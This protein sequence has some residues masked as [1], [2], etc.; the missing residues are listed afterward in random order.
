[1][2]AHTDAS[3]QEEANW[4]LSGLRAITVVRSL[5]QSELPPHLRLRHEWLVDSA[6]GEAGRVAQTCGYRARASSSISTNS[7]T[8]L[9][10]MRVRTKGMEYTG[11]I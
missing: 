3:G 10:C 11:R 5:R 1:M 2:E 6:P 4:E 8:S 7:E 9:I